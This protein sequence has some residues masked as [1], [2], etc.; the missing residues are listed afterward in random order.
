MLGA[1]F[2]STKIIQGAAGLGQ[3]PLTAY[4]DGVVGGSVQNPEMPGP[5]TSYHD[6]SLG[7][8]DGMLSAFADGVVGGAPPEFQ[9]PGKLAAYHDG[10]LGWYDQAAHGLGQDENDT[11]A[12]N[13]G[14]LGP[15][16]DDMTAVGPLQSYHDGSLG[17]YATA[18]GADPAPTL[19][20]GDAHTMQEL[21]TA[22]ALTA[23]GQT[24][25]PDAQKV[26]TPDWYTN[27]I[28]DPQ[29]TLLWEYIVSAIPAFKGKSV[30]IDIGAQ[31]YPNAVGIGFLVAALSAPQSGTYGPDYMKANLPILYSW[32]TAGGGNVLPPFLSLADKTTGTRSDSTSIKMST[33]AM[34]GLGAVAALGL[35]LVL[36][37]KRK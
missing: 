6:G 9:M 12:W 37:K 32:F 28:W 10:S 22:M 27:G 21:K 25:T 36:R 33:I 8:A 2:G 26:Y 23:P 14:V 30:S 1:Y 13:N 18:M 34:Y 17:A 4:A 16:Q 19:D 35:V 29:A 20:L 5:L 24:A 11:S 31:S 7:A 3:G 15:H